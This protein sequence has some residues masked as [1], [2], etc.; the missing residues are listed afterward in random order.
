MKRVLDQPEKVLDIMRGVADA[1]IM[2]RFK[3]LEAHEISEKKP[4]DLVT[5]ADKES[6]AALTRYLQ[7]LLPG[8]VVIGEEGHHA[9]PAT[10]NAL[11]DPG[12]VWIVDPV[13]GTYNFAHGKSPFTV[14]VALAEDGETKAGWI[15]DP[16]RGDAV[17][18]IPGSGAMQQDAAGKSTVIHRP[19][20]TYEAS[21]MTSGPKLRS[22]L[23][24][25]AAELRTPLPNLIDRYR[26]AGREYMDII[27][28]KID[29]TRYGGILKP[30]DHAAGAMIVGEAGGQARGILSNEPYRLTASLG[31]QSI[32]VV[33][34]GANWAAFR[35]LVKRADE[36][37]NL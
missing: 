21:T 36:L 30:W 34:D 9:D 27:T 12:P 6:E 13:D 37:A 22:R 5:I 1:E 11:G 23:A 16:V 10:L 2:P 3:T 8:S 28:G 19:E 25:A 4:G 18:A 7:S 20:R 35:N 26:C 15:I 33:G 31:T 24:R 17:W 14:I 32:G 29:L